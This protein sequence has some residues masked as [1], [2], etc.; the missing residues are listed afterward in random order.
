MPESGV[1][2]GLRAV[3]DSLGSALAARAGLDLRWGPELALDGSA[4]AAALRAAGASWE[5]VALG[6]AGR[7]FWDLHVGI[8]PLES[9]Y[10]IGLHWTSALDHEVRPWMQVAVPG[11]AL[12]FAPV[13]GEYQLLCPGAQRAAVHSAQSAVGAA[14]EIASRVLP[15]VHR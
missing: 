13:A 2:E 7:P 14:L 15:R 3:Y 11:G 10:S 9:G 1:G 6:F 8:L 5:W 4:A 12:Q